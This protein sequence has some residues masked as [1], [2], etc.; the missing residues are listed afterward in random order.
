[1]DRRTVLG[2]VGSSVSIPG[3]YVVWNRFQSAS[4]P[5]SMDV[6]T[7]YVTGNVFGEPQSEYDDVGPRKVIHRLIQDGETTSE[8]I[9]FDDSAIEFAE[10]TDFDESYLVVVQTGMQTA[11]DLELESIARTNDRLYFD[12]AVEHPLWR[13]VDDDLSTHSL[14]I[15]I[16]DRV[17]PVPESVSV[18]IHGY[19]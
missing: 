6:E 2:L 4:M 3:G 7:L 12:V 19:V 1:M 11:P 10:A 18:D 5:E 13:G 15:R 14:L 16:T 9:T 17:H 8:E